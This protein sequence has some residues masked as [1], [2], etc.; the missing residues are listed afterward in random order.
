MSSRNF[1]TSSLEKG[2]FKKIIKNIPFIDIDPINLSNIVN[3]NGLDK[4]FLLF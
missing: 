2:E 3:W 4:K 1:E